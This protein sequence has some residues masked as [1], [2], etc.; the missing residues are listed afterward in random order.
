MAP[1]GKFGRNT[2]RPFAVN[3]CICEKGSGDHAA[4]ARRLIEPEQC[5]MVL[6]FE[7]A[8]YSAMRAPSPFLNA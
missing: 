2:F 8:L 5:R 6:T 7:S 1:A 3:T 4:M